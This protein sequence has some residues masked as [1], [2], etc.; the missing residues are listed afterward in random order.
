VLAPRRARAIATLAAA[1]AVAGSAGGCRVDRPGADVPGA[2]PT[3]SSH[4]AVAE[5]PAG[6][7]ADPLADLDATLDAV[8]HDLGASASE[9]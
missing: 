8:E 9:G 5:P 1:L 2:A 7:P 4:S 3:P 6:R